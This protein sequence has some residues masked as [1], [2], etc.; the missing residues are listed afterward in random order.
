MSTATVIDLSDRGQQESL[1]AAI[2]C[3]G[4]EFWA[5]GFFKAT[6]EIAIEA[7]AQAPLQGWGA[8]VVTWF[9]KLRDQEGQHQQ[10]DRLTLDIEELYD[11][12]WCCDAQL[13]K[14]PFVHDIGGEPHSFSFEMP[15][16]LET[17]EADW[18]ARIDQNGENDPDKFNCTASSD[19]L[20]AE[21][22]TAMPA[23]LALL[24]M[25]PPATPAA[26]TALPAVMSPATSGI[27]PALPTVMPQA[28]PVATPAL[29][30]VVSSMTPSLDTG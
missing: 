7:G 20:P 4:S 5:E 19:A 2:D 17:Y 26:T 22:P 14:D 21:M 9:N 3:W 30:S 18:C 27:T 28:T 11:V 16:E 24:A 8:P 6:A 29:P 1:L 23:T 13:A 15:H 12:D 10:D 25:M